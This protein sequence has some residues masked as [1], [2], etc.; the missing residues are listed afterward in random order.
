VARYFYIPLHHD[1]QGRNNQID[2]GFV[3]VM[4]VCC[5]DNC[6]MSCCVNLDEPAAYIFRLGQAHQNNITIGQLQLR[7]EADIKLTSSSSATQ[8]CTLNITVAQVTLF[9]IDL[10]HRQYIHI[11][12]DKFQNFSCN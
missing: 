11:Y 8:Y 1:A 5:K 10:L 6:L 2:D 4:T 3:D 9:L 12:K 7:L